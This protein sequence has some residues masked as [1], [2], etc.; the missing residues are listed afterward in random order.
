MVENVWIEDD[1]VVVSKYTMEVYGKMM[2]YIHYV[3]EQH[4]KIHAEVVA[5]QDRHTKEG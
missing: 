2:E 4:P 5:Y 1:D 3:R